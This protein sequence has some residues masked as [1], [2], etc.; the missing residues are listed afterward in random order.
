VN[1]S[2]VSSRRQK[3]RW[4]VVALLVFGALWLAFHLRSVFNPLLLGLL[5]AYMLNPLVEK[6][7]A[8]GVSRTKA[9]TVLFAAA[10]FVLA[11]GSAY[12]TYKT[13]EL[14]RTLR[15]S[16]VGERILDPENSHDA[17][18]IAH[19]QGKAAAPPLHHERPSVTA[20]EPR[21][22]HATLVRPL[23]ENYYLDLNNDGERKVGLVERATIFVTAELAQFHVGR[24]EL[25]E[26]ARSLEGHASSVTQW[27]IR[28]TQGARRSFDQVGHFFSYLLL[29]PVYT[30]FLLMGFTGIRD[31]AREHLP[32]AYREQIV[33]IAEKIDVQVAAFFRGKLFLC[34]LK[35]IVTWVGLWISGVPF[36]FAVGLSAGFLSIIPF[37]GPAIGGL[38]A[39]FLAFSSPAPP[40][41]TYQLIGI[42]LSFVA[43]E[44]VEAVTQPVILGAEVGMNPVLLLLSFFVFGELFGLFG[45][46]LAVP[47]MSVFKTL[48]EELLLPEIRALAE[49]PGKQP[50]EASDLS[51]PAPAVPNFSRAN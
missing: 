20:P 47:I 2:G 37:A 30:F 28:L 43:A 41:F 31:S 34:L 49:E 17:T 45:L 27:G 4:G 36:A 21:H 15:D 3:L 5:F 38:M 32:G 11:S 48:F 39:V 40:A 10:L 42:V 13:Y 6:L 9:V 1:L 14:A 44:G 51:P 33:R 50:A 8:K 24:D 29:V 26:L 18:L 16:M 7:E 23:G 35:G 12:L 46:L 19:S 25:T 22:P